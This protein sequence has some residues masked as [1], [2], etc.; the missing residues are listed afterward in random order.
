MAEECR[1][2]LQSTPTGVLF[3][4]VRRELFRDDVDHPA[5]LAAIHGLADHLNAL[6]REWNSRLKHTRM[7]LDAAGRSS[8]PTQRDRNSEENAEQRERQC[9]EIHQRIEELEHFA[10]HFALVETDHWIS[11]RWQ[12]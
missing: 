3:D 4:A 2:H 5:L 6:D 8:Q 10:R 9:H 1:R 11:K 12:G 7:L